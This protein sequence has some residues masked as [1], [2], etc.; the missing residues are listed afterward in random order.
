ME[1]E[2]PLRTHH[3]PSVAAEQGGV[4]S[5]RQNKYQVAGGVGLP[6]WLGR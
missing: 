6:W 4:S 3:F 1:A 2:A 5:R